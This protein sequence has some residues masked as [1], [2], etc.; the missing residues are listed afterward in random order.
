M[1]PV[2]AEPQK[3]GETKLRYQVMLTETANSMLEET[4]QQL[5]ISR[6]EVIERAI[7]KGALELVKKETQKQSDL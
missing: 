4:S 1:R 2:K 5:G 7:R 3:Y 6:S